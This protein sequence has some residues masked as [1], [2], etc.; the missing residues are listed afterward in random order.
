MSQGKQ[1][2]GFD[3]G[4]TVYLPL[5][6]FCREYGVEIGNAVLKGMDGQ[7]LQ[8]QLERDALTKLVANLRDGRTKDVQQALKKLAKQL[9]SVA[10]EKR[11]RRNAG[12]CR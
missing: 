12:Q 10:R 11:A 2:T 8:Q 1:S 3:L 5:L 6:T 7:T 9:P 4:E